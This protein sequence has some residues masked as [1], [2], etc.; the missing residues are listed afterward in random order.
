MKHYFLFGILTILISCSKDPTNKDSFTFP[1]E[2]DEHEA[3]WMGWEDNKRGEVSNEFLL[4]V[5]KVL[6]K[7]VKLNIIVQNDSVEASVRQKVN[8]MNIPADSITF[9]KH[10]N[11]FFWMRDPGPFFMKNK[12]GDLAITHFKWKQYNGFKNDTTYA[13]MDSIPAIKNLNG[14]GRYFA[15]LMDLNVIYESKTYAEGGGIEAVSYT[16]LT[17]P[18][19]RIV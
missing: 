18:T 10:H 19:K 5:A 15:Q 1:P 17:L 16:H 6:T 7:Y 13:Q 14:Y 2:W 12:N 3:I 11:T 9:F 8:D 4:D